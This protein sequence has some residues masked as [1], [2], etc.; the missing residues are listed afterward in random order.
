MDITTTIPGDNTSLLIS[1]GQTYSGAIDFSSIVD[2]PGFDIEIFSVDIVFLIVDDQNDPAASSTFVTVNN[3]EPGFEN[4]RLVGQSFATRRYLRGTQTRNITTLFEETETA[5]LAISG[6]PA[7]SRASTT[8]PSNSNSVSLTTISET[9]TVGPEIRDPDDFSGLPAFTRNTMIDTTQ[10]QTDTFEEGFNLLLS[11]RTVQNALT[12]DRKLNYT[13][14]AT[15]GDFLY[16]GTFDPIVTY[17]RTPVE[18]TP[19][20]VPLPATAPLLLFG[21]GLLWGLRR[22]RAARLH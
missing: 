13:M 9:R 22:V 17:F 8:T 5:T 20:A 3:R 4:Y 10:F 11:G 7:A 2:Q 12:P 16:V 21:A 14:T 1:E 15:D 18:D 19:T 6:F